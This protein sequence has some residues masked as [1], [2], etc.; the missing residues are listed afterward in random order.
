MEAPN[1]VPQNF[2]FFFFFAMAMRAREFLRMAQDGQ[3]NGVI[4][5]RQWGE[6]PGVQCEALEKIAVAFGRFRPLRV[7]S[8]VDEVRQAMQLFKDAAVEMMEE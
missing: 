4:V 3:V 1:G 2:F 8:T 5:G 7:G 6:A